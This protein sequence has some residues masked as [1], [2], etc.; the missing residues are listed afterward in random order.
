METDAGT[1]DAIGNTPPVSGELPDA[2]LALHALL[3]SYA[4]TLEMLNKARTFLWTR[5]EKPRVLRWLPV[6]AP[7]R[8]VRALI[9]RHVHQCVDALKC[10]VIRNSALSDDAVE[11]SRDLEMLQQFEQSLRNRVRLSLIWP[12]PLLGVLFVAFILASIYHAGYRT[13]LGDL[14][15]AALNLNRTA[16][17]AAIESAHR[18]A[19]AG[20]EGA[21]HNYLYDIQFFA[22]AAMIVAWAAVLVIVPFLPTAA[23]YRRTKAQWAAVEADA[24]AAVGARTG[25]GI[26]IDLVARLLL[27]PAVAVSS[28][29]AFLYGAIQN[30][31]VLLVAGAICA[32]LIVFA[33][34]EL[35][36]RYTER[37][38]RIESGHRPITQMALSLLVVLSL[39]LF[40]YLRMKR[41]NE[42]PVRTVGRWT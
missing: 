2:T 20:H 26:E 9:V 18:L 4:D 34:L 36:F 29:S 38:R 32:V 5:F 15:T 3:T 31:T 40:V 17:I 10:G 24:L 12:L 11:S 30:D 8:V 35:R 22:S 16:A 7:R 14:T 27:F 39:G 6:P 28:Y 1:R 42:Q 41:I 37:C 21:K 13:L 25:R 23:I 19:L 33:S